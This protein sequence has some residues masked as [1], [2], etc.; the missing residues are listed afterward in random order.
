M[1]HAKLGF[2]CIVRAKL[3]TVVMAVGSPPKF[4]EAIA[5]TERL[6]AEG[7]ACGAHSH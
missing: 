3:R 2:L 7:T 1:V 5:E 4:E 6:I